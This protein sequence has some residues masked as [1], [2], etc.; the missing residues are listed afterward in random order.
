MADFVSSQRFAPAC[1]VNRC[2]KGGARRESPSCVDRQAMFFSSSS[3]WKLTFKFYVLCH[4]LIA[5]RFVAGAFC[6]APLTVAA[7]ARIRAERRGFIEQTQ[8][9][10]KYIKMEQA[11]AHAP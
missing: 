8:A 7:A 2:E 11:C 4:T 3:K 1:G 9:L 6:A 10:S 5:D